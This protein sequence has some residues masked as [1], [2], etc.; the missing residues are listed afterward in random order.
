M[1]IDIEKNKQEFLYRFDK[2]IGGRTG[3][4]KV[5]AY[6]LKSDF[7]TAPASTKYH[8]AELGGLCLHSLHVHDVLSQMMFTPGTYWAQ[9]AQEKGVTEETVAVVAL[10]HDMC[11]TYTY[12]KETKNVKTYDS[13]DIAAARAAGEY[14]K[15]DSK[16]DF[17][18]KQVE[19][20][21]FDDQ[22]PLGHGEKSVMLILQL[23]MSL[24]GEETFAIRWHM[25]LSEPKEDWGIMNRAF[26]KYAM[27]LAVHLADMQA[28]HL[29]EGEAFRD[30]FEVTYQMDMEEVPDFDEEETEP[31]VPEATPDKEESEEHPAAT[32]MPDPVSESIPFSEEDTYGIQEE[33]LNE[34]F[35][36]S[37]SA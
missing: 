12:S 4:D 15:H 13:E 1:S 29:L 26:N 3:A 23:G 19:G 7:F 37:E 31:E 36:V 30:M 34:F 33:D 2:Y 11:K 35:A 8:L 27:V 16:G 14:I 28:S 22:M 25:G 18:W 17:I 6:L 5:R 9:Y 24:T 21:I 10:L 32:E 20:Y